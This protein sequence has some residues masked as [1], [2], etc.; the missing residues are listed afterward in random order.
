M[1]MLPTDAPERADLH[2]HGELQ[3]HADAPERSE[4]AERTLLPLLSIRGLSKVYGPTTVVDDIQLTIPH[5]TIHALLGESGAGKSTLI[6]MLAGMIRADAGHIEIDGVRR[7]VRSVKDAQ[8]LGIVAL[9]QELTLVPTLSAPENIFLGQR[10]HGALGLIS[11]RD[12]E[13]DAAVQLARL[14]QRVPL[15]TP[16]GELS[17]VQQT[18][19]ALARALASDSRLLMLDEPTAALTAAEA[20]QLF[21]VLQSL[22]A[23]GTSIIYVSRRLD[24]VFRLADTV[25]VLRSGTLVWTKP[26]G[27]TH[28]GDVV[29]AMTGL[30]EPVSLPVRA[31]TPALGT[32]ILRVEALHGHRLQ[33]VSLSASAGRILGIAGLAGS[34]RSE[35]LRLIAGD[36]RMRAGQVLL[37]G[38]PVAGGSVRRA[39]ERGIALVP[40]ERRRQGLVMTASIRRNI[41]LANEAAAGWL[42]LASRRRERAV[43]ERGVVQLPITESPRPRSALSRI[44]GE[45]SSSDQQKVMLARYLERKPRVLLLDEPTRGVD[46]HTKTEIHAAIRRLADAGVA[47]IVVS[48]EIPELLGLV[49]EIAVLNEG[50]LGALLPAGDAD[51]ATILQHC[52]RKAD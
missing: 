4:L 37:D 28:T 25:T 13:Q 8:K 52:Y 22:R 12:L 30:A 47:V 46:R 11:R 29:A 39:M 18:M 5:G 27:E 32:E 35:L 16:V 42:G 51:E 41:A 33:G 38:V 24:E 23:A 2:E 9:P 36:Q 14:G 10:Q 3:E 43:A 26:V 19:V 45:L 31:P 34:G 1:L 48:S 44:V 15:R 50:K 49:D 40:A 21:G 7:R 6:S 17:A 20:E